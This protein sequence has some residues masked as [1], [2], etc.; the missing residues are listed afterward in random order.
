MKLIYENKLR[1]DED[2][3]DFVLEGKAGISFPE[4]KMRIESVISPEEGQ[5]ANYVLWCNKDF[6]KDVQ[7]EWDFRPIA[8]PGLAM[9]FLAAKGKGGEDLFDGSLKE[10]TGEYSQYH[11]GDINAFHISYFRRKEKDERQFH[12]C[13]LRKSYGFYL[14]AQGADPIPDAAD[15]KEPYRLKAVKKDNTLGFFVNDLKIFEFVDDG[16]TYGP[17]L[18]GG[19]IG[20]RQLAPMIGEYSNLKVYEL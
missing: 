13:N 6:P 9:I 20:F 3:K 10:R 18:E 1:S 8:E 7:I 11:H 16:C 5:K 12:T 4:G 15:A 17:L 14:V 2:I 19:K